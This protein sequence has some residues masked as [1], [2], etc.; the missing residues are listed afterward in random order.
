MFKECKVC[1]S[2]KKQQRLPCGCLS[3][4]SCIYEWS[5]SYIE[6]R[7]LLKEI[8]IP[9]P[10]DTCKRLFGVDHL[11]HL[12]D[13]SQFNDISTLLT[14]NYCRQTPDIRFCP[15]SYCTYAG[16]IQN[17]PCKSPLQCGNCGVQ[18]R[19]PANYSLGEKLCNKISSNSRAKD[20]YLSNLRKVVFGHACPNCS[21]VIFKIGGCPHIVCGKC[22]FEFCW[23]CL[24]S[25]ISYQHL[26]GRGKWCGLRQIYKII[27]YIFLL[28]VLLSPSISF[29][30]F[31]NTWKPLWGGV[32]SLA[33]YLFSF[34]AILGQLFPIVII[35]TY[36]DYKRYNILRYKK[37][38]ITCLTLYLIINSLL[39]AFIYYMAIFGLVLR[40]GITAILFLVTGVTF[41]I[42]LDGIGR[43][44]HRRRE[45]KICLC[46]S[47]VFGSLF[48][49]FIYICS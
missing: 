39:I 32:L 46:L 25:Y 4:S 18:W 38:F 22:K 30:Y 7:P 3:C 5:K 31:P 20:D 44:G 15:D 29:P 43:H 23:D 48:A 8:F 1:F 16:I 10:L 36:M 24:G 47:I 33:T 27:I 19:D 34:F 41:C 13:N 26:P 11:K 28:F 21:A 42:F 6:D 9:C 35:G 14:K 49:L 12:L 2:K 17:K 45:A 40:S 37:E